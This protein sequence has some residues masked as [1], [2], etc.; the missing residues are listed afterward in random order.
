MQYRTLCLGRADGDTAVVLS[1]LLL[2][3]ALTKASP[4]IPIYSFNWA[5][6]DDSSGIDM[7]HQEDRNIDSTKGSYQTLLPDGRTQLV[8]YNVEGDSG[9][10]ADV[11]YQGE[12]R[13][14][15]GERAP[16]RSYSRPILLQRQSSESSERAPIILRTS[17]PRRSY[18]EPIV[19]RTAAPRRS[20]GVPVVDLVQRYD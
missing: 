6:R 2:A 4:A 17:A 16:S 10:I 18:S 8:T 3:V 12:A 14:S 5:V 19:V 20:Y 13:Y 15:S 11:Q 9:Y 7:G 1:S